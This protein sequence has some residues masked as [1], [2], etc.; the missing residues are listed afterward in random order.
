MYFTL[1]PQSTLPIRH[2]LILD[3]QVPVSRSLGSEVFLRS[4]TQTFF[5]A[6]GS[7]C[8][9]VRFSCS[10]MSLPP[11]LTMRPCV[12]AFGQEA[13]SP[14]DVLIFPPG[15]KI[16]FSHMYFISLAG[17]IS[18]E[19][20]YHHL[21]VVPRTPVGRIR[22]EF[23]VSSRSVFLLCFEICTNT[24]GSPRSLTQ[25]RSLCSGPSSPAAKAL[26]TLSVQVDGHI[27][28]QGI[29]SSVVSPVNHTC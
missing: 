25:S 8:G 1:L 21:E 26:G 22:A 12:I 13:V 23:L 29:C 20:E 15:H 16:F 2:P 28:I 24:S 4:R 27:P 19:A 11:D 3:S 17:E 6:Q 9:P 10:P 5:A 18:K 7:L 14:R